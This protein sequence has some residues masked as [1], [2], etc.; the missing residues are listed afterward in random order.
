M[1]PRVCH[2][3]SLLSNSKIIR[4]AGNLRQSR[5][6]FIHFV[7][8]SRC[9]S[10]VISGGWPTRVG[11]AS[12][13]PPLLRRRCG[14][15]CQDRWESEIVS[16]TGPEEQPPGVFGAE[17]RI[18]LASSSFCNNGGKFKELPSATRWVLN[19]NSNR[20]AKVQYFFHQTP[21]YQKN[22]LKTLKPI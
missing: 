7:W 6:L 22:L 19:A 1:K 16:N 14:H 13:L 12:L 15:S 4:V 9:R 20:Y 2:R 18:L 8:S 3:L 21:C 11:S 10:Y 5:G 17:T